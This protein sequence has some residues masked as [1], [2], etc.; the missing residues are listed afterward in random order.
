[1]HDN[2]QISFERLLLKRVA[3][4]KE[5]YRLKVQHSCAPM[6]DVHGAYLEI[7]AIAC[8]GQFLHQNFFK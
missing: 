6:N 8:L 5:K 1:V 4:S 3:T 2:L 7:L